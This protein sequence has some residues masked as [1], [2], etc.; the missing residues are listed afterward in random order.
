MR[1][2]ACGL[3]SL[4]QLHLDGVPAS[5]GAHERLDCRVGKQRFRLWKRPLKRLLSQQQLPLP[6]FAHEDQCWG[7][8][9]AP[10]VGRR[11]IR[12]INRDHPRLLSEPTE[13][14]S[15]GDFRT[16]RFAIDPVTL[17][18]RLHAVQFFWQGIETLRQSTGCIDQAERV[19]DR[20]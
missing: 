20:S 18:R 13:T 16:N 4:R 9:D 2:N 5:I 8:T 12:H 15:I 19:S 11:A 7:F 10:A 14:F 6:V 3:A 17:Q 1:I